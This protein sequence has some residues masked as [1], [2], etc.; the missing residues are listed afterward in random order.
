MFLGKIKNLFRKHPAAK[1][2]ELSHE[3][4]TGPRLFLRNKKGNICKDILSLCQP[5]LA[6]GGCAAPP[7]TEPVSL[8][9]SPSSTAVSSE[10]EGVPSLRLEHLR[11]TVVV[12]PSNSTQSVPTSSTGVV[13]LLTVRPS[14]QPDAK[15][16]ACPSAATAVKQRKTAQMGVQGMSKQPKTAPHI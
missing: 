2:T 7:H 5:L 6:L 11:T 16:V 1:P 13:R 14:F 10:S 12:T 3:K 9:K 8:V 4:K 15:V